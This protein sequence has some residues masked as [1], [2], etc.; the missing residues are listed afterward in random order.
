MTGAA[1]GPPHT[2]PYMK[3]LPDLK[4]LHA[5]VGRRLREL[6]MA[7]SVTQVQVSD[8]VGLHHV[9]LSMYERGQREPSLDALIA[10]ARYYGVPL[11]DIVNEYDL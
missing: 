4:T 11:S 8:A 5:L 3:S 9:T 7:K 10:L 1:P 2:G 6:R